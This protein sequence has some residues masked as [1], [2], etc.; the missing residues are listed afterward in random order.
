MIGCQRLGSVDVLTLERPGMVP[1]M[2][3]ELAERLRAAPGGRPLVLTGAGHRFCFGADLKW[4]GAAS[5][6][7]AALGG[8][9]MAHHEVVRAMRAAP[10]PVVAAVN[11]PAAGGGVSLALAADY[12]LA[13]PNATFTAAYFRLGITP[14][15]GNSAFLVR[16]LGPARA[17]D[18]LLTNRSLSAEEALFWGLVSEVVPANQLLDRASEVAQ[19]FAQVPAETLLATRLLLDG[20]PS[21]DEVLD[22]EQAAML[23]AVQRPEFR[24][25]LDAFL[26]R[27]S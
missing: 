19:G 13:S 2:M 15:G 1:E 4:A 14:D 20:S 26:N 27:R 12:R 23:A 22:K 8:L 5:D 21:L 17:M 9:L 10:V 18:L 7:G 6:P 25:S 11:G 24:R 16:M 3:A